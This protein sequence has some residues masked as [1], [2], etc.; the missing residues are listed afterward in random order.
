MARSK[1]IGALLAGLF[2]AGCASY[3]GR[4]LVPG[5]SRSADVES[6]MG[7]P[8][9]KVA[10][11][12]GETVW[13]YPRQPFGRQTY[14]VRVGPDG[15]VRGVDQRL[16]VENMHKLAAGTTTKKEARE[17][18]GPPWRVSRQDRQQRDVWEY[19][20][21]DA[22]QFEYNLY[23]QFSGDGVLREVLLLRDLYFEP[24]GSTKD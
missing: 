2:L 22:R 6:L 15:I 12:N 17:L 9:E 8:A 24:G 20:M 7:A 4:G 3:S 13:F 1:L 10:A 23:I 18:L 21:Y 5:Q 16:T 19:S 11:A 14:A